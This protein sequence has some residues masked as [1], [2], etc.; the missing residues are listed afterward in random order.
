MN[1]FRTEIFLKK[2]TFTVDYHKKSIFIGSCFTKNIG[3][4][5]LENQFPVLINPFGVLYNPLSVQKALEII[6][7]K[8]EFTEN[9]LHFRNDKWFSF[10]HHSSFS[11]PD[12]KEVLKKINSKIDE[13]HSFLKEAESL[14]ITFGTSW[15]FKLQETNQVVA[16]CHKLPSNLFNRKILNIEEIVHSW[17]KMITQLKEFNPK[18]KVVFT[19]SP[20]RHW[21][22]GAVNNQL[23]KSIL[24]VAIHEILK[25]F[26][27]ISYFPSYEIMMDDLRDYRFY[28]DDFLHPNSQAINYIW[29]KFK[30]AFIEEDTIQI[31]KQVQKIV[32]AVNHRPFHPKTNSY[33]DFLGSNLDKIKQLNI[34]YPFIDFHEEKLYFTEEIEKYF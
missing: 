32:K 5:L 27:H 18:L 14:F 10:D 19:V 16:N 30:S 2:S 22:D 26:E 24:I 12:K 11:A 33:K 28:N 1:S 8:T 21:K 3:S 6:I 4:K 23:S 20:I 34:K 29:D 17:E 15:Y 13:A 25:E 9:D 7:H 31:S